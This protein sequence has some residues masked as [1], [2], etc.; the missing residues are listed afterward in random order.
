M[1]RPQ[2]TK[3]PLSLCGVL[4]ALCGDAWYGTVYVGVGGRVTTG[5]VQYEYC[6]CDCLTY[7]FSPDVCL[8]LS[9]RQGAHL[10]AMTDAYD[11]KALAKER[12]QRRGVPSAATT[13]THCNNCCHVCHSVNTMSINIG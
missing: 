5:T 11:L 9:H 12:E 4:L 2:T 3:S 7:F 1:K 10:L 6:V 8:Y 13:T